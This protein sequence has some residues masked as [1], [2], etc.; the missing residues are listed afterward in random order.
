LLRGPTKPYIEEY[1]MGIEC[2]NNECKK[3]IGTKWLNIL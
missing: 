1:Q 3:K 2:E